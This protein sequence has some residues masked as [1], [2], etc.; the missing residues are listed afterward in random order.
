MPGA[1]AMEYPEYFDYPAYQNQAEDPGEPIGQQSQQQ[2]HFSRAVNAHMPE[3]PSGP[4]YHPVVAPMSCDVKPRLTK[5]QHDLLETHFQKQHKPS[6]TI[7]RGF[8][9]TLSVPLDKI[10][11]SCTAGTAMCS[12]R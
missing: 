10:N 3:Q 11:V 1:F 12:I 6:T 8:A 4:L 2:Q 9:D 5:E 7:K